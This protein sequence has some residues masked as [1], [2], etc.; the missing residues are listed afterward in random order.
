M[1]EHNPK[2]GTEYSLLLDPNLDPKALAKRLKA[3]PDKEV[4]LSTRVKNIDIFLS[5]QD[6]CITLNWTATEIGEHDYVALYNRDL[7]G[8]PEGYL[9]GQ[10]RWV[11]N[12]TSPQITSI[13][14]SSGRPGYWMVYCT[15]EN[16]RYVIQTEVYYEF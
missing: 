2:K 4:E 5:K 13:P 1:Y 15:W 12:N 10:W 14:V 11:Y 3:N 6:G 9:E 16:E 7:K 8:D